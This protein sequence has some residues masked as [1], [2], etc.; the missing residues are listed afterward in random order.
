[1]VMK[2]QTLEQA[3]TVAAVQNEAVQPMSSRE[4]LER[5][6]DLLDREPARRLSTLRETEHCAPQL[7]ATM[8][9]GDSPIAVAFADPVLRAQ[10]LRDDTYGEA[11]RFFDISD[12]QLH[13]ILCYCQFGEAM[14]ARTAARAICRV[15]KA[16]DR[17]AWFTRIW[18]NL[19]GL[20]SGA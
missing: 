7:R 17:S 8:R 9:G 3:R 16:E 12:W 15:I 5:W 14:S 13:N 4:R 6:A 20:R 2:Y 11:K 10:G 18:Q 1:M 19:S